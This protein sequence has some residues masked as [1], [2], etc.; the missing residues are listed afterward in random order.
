MLWKARRACQLVLPGLEPKLLR[1][2]LIRFELL[3]KLRRLKERLVLGR[4]NILRLIL[5]ELVLGVLLVVAHVGV[6]HSEV[7]AATHELSA[8]PVVAAV[9]KLL[10]VITKI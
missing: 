1:S 4:Q 8:L 5:I 2:L 6:V 3:R 9:I 10:V 7:L